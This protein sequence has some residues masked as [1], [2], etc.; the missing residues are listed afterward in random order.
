MYGKRQILPSPIATPAVAKIAPYLPRK[1]ERV[2]ALT[3]LWSELLATHITF[4][5]IKELADI[6]QSDIAALSQSL[7]KPA[8]VRRAKRYEYSTALSAL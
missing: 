7:Q 8:L 5:L 2:S 6:H 4:D 1:R 3:L